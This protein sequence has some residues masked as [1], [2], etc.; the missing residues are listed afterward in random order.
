MAAAWTASMM[1]S[2]SAPGWRVTVTK[3]LTPNRLA[4]PGA[5]NTAAANGLVA[6][7]AEVTL[8]I[9]AS[10]PSRVNFMASGFGVGDGVAVAM[11]R[12]Y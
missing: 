10:L 9:S 6:S 2:Q 1:G 3:S 5:A 8:T 7:A 4:T 11:R 12:L